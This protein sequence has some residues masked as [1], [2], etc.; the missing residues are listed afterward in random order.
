MKLRL[1][2]YQETEE[3]FVQSVVLDD[4]GAY[5]FLLKLS[6]IYPGAIRPKKYF[7][8][9]FTV[10][11]G[12]IL[13]DIHLKISQFLLASSSNTEMSGWKKSVIKDRR[14]RSPWNIR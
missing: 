14:K 3:V 6:I 10:P 11:V 2:E 4:I 7:P 1:T 8:Q 13:W 9:K 12:P 5:Q